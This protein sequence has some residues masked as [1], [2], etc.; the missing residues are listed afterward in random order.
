MSD[1]LADR[2]K[3]LELR[4]TGR[5]ATP[6]RPLLARL[7]MRG[8]RAFTKG[9]ER[10]Y[11]PMVSHCMIEATRFLVEREAALVGYTHGDEITLA[12]FAPESSSQ[13][14]PFDGRFQ[15]LASILAGMASA[16]FVQTAYEVLPEKRE[17][18]PHFDC[19]V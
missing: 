9:L 15:K 4:E 10:P 5:R 7:D 1:P 3:E 14:Y 8:F 19:R 11:S 12:W 13:A 18:T 2:C 16:R 6:G 17:E